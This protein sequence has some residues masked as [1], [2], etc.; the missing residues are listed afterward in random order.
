[1]SSR[2]FCNKLGKLNKYNLYKFEK[3]K[4]TKKQDIYIQEM[5]KYLLGV[6]GS[7]TFRTGLAKVRN[8]CLPV[9]KNKTY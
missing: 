1:M 7:Q 6:S 2:C 4:I 9:N 8:V 5:D 3:T